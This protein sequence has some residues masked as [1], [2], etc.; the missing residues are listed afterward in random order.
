[1][2]DWLKTIL[3]WLNEFLPGF[4]VGMGIGTSEKAE[5]EKELSKAKL[6]LQ[7]REDEIN[8][9]KSFSGMSDADV[10]N[11]VKSGRDT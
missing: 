9:E 8:S 5:L 3:D 4:L 6:Q 10:V 7:L 2:S 11:A 1:M